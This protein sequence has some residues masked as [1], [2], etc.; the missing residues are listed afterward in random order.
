[1][2]NVP[3]H[4]IV[5]S[6]EII[7]LLKNEDALTFLNE[8]FD[9]QPDLLSL[10]YSGKVNFN[11]TKLTQILHLYHK[12]KSK[13][14]IWVENRC[15]MH[16]KSYAQCSH[17]EVAHFKSTLFS[18]K[19]ALDLTG[20]LGVDSYYLSSSFNQVTCL[21]RDKTT[22]QF[23]TFNSRKLN[24][25]NILYVHADVDNFEFNDH[26]D[27]IYVDPDRRKDDTRIL[28]D[29][30]AYS[31]N[32]VVGQEK[33]LNYSDSVVVKLSPMVDLTLLENTFFNLKDIYVIGYKNE[34]KEILIHLTK[35]N[36]AGPKRYAVNIL[37]NKIHKFTSSTKTTNSGTNEAGDI[38]L[39]PSKPLIKAGLSHAYCEGIGLCPI[40]NNGH[41]YLHKEPLLDFDGRQF[42]IIKALDG[43]WKTIS[44]YLKSNK[45]K[46]IEI[47][48]RHFYEDVKSI[49]KKLKVNEGGKTSL[50]FTVNKDGKA[51][52]LHTERITTT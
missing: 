27:L 40:I 30:E 29:I 39:E 47:A 17:W 12:A 16:E 23:A 26:Y 42:K 4:D 15:A 5:Q 35:D 10:K 8:N 3:P 9:E 2:N 18:G 22:H 32:I 6:N 49:R 33:W 44:K 25:N 1:M 43:N 19:S 24:A 31:P 38:L 51:L 20:G 7:E 45:I 14:P 52:C 48:Q 41:Y 50:H 46:S 37:N 28:G 21:E 11:L 34:V 13:I 36:I